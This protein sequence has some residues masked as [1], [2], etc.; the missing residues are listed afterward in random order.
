MKPLTA[1]LKL[2]LLIFMMPGLLTAFDPPLLATADDDDPWL[3]LSKKLV[4]GNVTLQ[5]AGSQI[6]IT[7]SNLNEALVWPGAP[8]DVW[9]YACAVRNPFAA[10]RMEDGFVLN[11]TNFRVLKDDHDFTLSAFPPFAFFTSRPTTI[12][13]LAGGAGFD[14][15]SSQ[16]LLLVDVKTAAHVL[17]PLNDGQMPLWLDRSNHPPAFATQHFDGLG[18]SWRDG[19]WRVN[20]VFRF[21]GGKYRHDAAT[22]RKLLAARFQK[23]QLTP[24]QRRR[25]S[26]IEIQSPDDVIFPE[27]KALCDF[28]YYGDRSG[29]GKAV[30]QLIAN[31]QPSLRQR[32]KAF[33]KS[34][35]EIAKEPQPR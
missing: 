30:D 10:P 34:L 3:K 17:I 23:S 4:I 1:S 24:G 27:A 20:Q 8:G 6:H 16:E 11:D 2:G 21:S 33:R 18:P 9:D 19:D 31:L 25:L 35:A 32:V 26:K 12:G 5:L 13:L 22:E 15:G 14:G 7:G 29:K 28:V